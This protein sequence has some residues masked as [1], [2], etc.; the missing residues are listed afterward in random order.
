MSKSGTT[1]RRSAP[2]SDGID[3]IINLGRKLEDLEI[4]LYD[5]SEGLL[6]LGSDI[7]VTSN[8]ATWAAALTA[9]TVGIEIHNT[10]MYYFPKSMIRFTNVE[11]GSVEGQ[12]A[13]ATMM[14]TP[15]NVSGKPGGWNL[16]WY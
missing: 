13:R 15:M 11:M 9:R 4:K 5:I 12:V 10:A 6:T 2:I 8:V 7:S 14:I 3:D 1:R 16:E